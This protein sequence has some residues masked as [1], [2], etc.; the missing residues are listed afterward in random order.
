MASRDFRINKQGIARM[1]REIQKEFDKHPIQV[2]VHADTPSHDT[3]LETTVYNGPVIN[4]HGDRAQIAWNNTVAS[5]SQVSEE[6]APGFEALAETLVSVLRHLP[7]IPLD[8]VERE[9]AEAATHDVLQE[10]TKEQPDSGLVRRGA[11]AVKGVLASVLLSTQTGISD[12]T[13][14]IARSLVE[15]LGSALQ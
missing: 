11:S 4:I 6:I 1:T 10:L 12:G 9:T 8:D 15:R 5:Q 13:R 14:E 3:Q 7:E 2:P